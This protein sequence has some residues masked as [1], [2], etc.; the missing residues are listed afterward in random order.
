M[1]ASRSAVSRVLVVV[2][3]GAFAAQLPPAEADDRERPVG[4]AAGEDRSRAELRRAHAAKHTYARMAVSGMENVPTFE[5]YLDSL[6]LN[7]PES[8]L[9]HA[10]SRVAEL[11]AVRQRERDSHQAV[12]DHA[13]QRVATSRI[14][15]DIAKGGGA[16]R[17]ALA[18]LIGADSRN[19]YAYVESMSHYS[20]EH[21]QSQSHTHESSMETLRRDTARQIRDAQLLQV[22]REAWQRGDWKLPGRQA[23]GT[24]TGA[25][26]AGGDR[27]SRVRFAS[28]RQ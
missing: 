8:F 23:P 28:Q 7:P 13:Q 4:R 1:S 20:T 10:R 22:Y 25:D 27:G 14:Y 26:A 11:I 24:F 21:M 12:R 9:T 16:A 19:A 18:R 17:A 5:E 6:G 2:A 3:V 15:A